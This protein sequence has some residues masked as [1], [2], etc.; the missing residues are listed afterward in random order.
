MIPY[1]NC[2]FK[3]KLIPKLKAVPICTKVPRQFCQ[4]NYV[5]GEKIR[6]EVLSLWCRLIENDS[7]DETTTSSSLAQQQTEEE[8]EV[9][10]TTELTV[11]YELEL[12]TTFEPELTTVMPDYQDEEFDASTLPTYQQDEEEP[13][14]ELPSDYAAP[15]VDSYLPFLEE[16]EENDIEYSRPLSDFYSGPLSTDYPTLKPFTDSSAALD[17]LQPPSSYLP[18]TGPASAIPENSQEA[19]LDQELSPPDEDKSVAKP[20]ITYGPPPPTIQHSGKF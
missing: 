19:A 10:T 3:T 1:E 20:D 13:L 18:P 17:V 9:T 6:K 16:I 5:R 4:V 15:P 8:D 11:D 2:A 7:T 14:D 12:S